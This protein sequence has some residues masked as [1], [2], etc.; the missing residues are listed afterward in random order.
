MGVRLQ[1]FTSV[2]TTILPSL[3]LYRE[4]EDRKKI[5]HLLALVGTDEG[6]I[7]YFHREPPH[8]VHVSLNRDLTADA[9]MKSNTV[10]INDLKNAALA[11][12][13]KWS[14]GIGNVSSSTCIFPKYF[15]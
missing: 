2:H 4:L 10:T 13:P 6:E 14:R 11:S 1:Y 5:Q 12:T 15:Q 9:L 3:M 7:T 8:K